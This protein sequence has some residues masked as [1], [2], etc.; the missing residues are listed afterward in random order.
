M[1]LKTYTEQLDNLPGLEIVG[2]PITDNHAAWLFTILVPDAQALRDY[3]FTKD[4]ESG[5]V[6]FRNDYYTIFGGRRNNLPNMDSVES[7]Y[8]VLPL[9]NHVTVED[10]KRIC[11]EVS[12][13]FSLE[14]NNAEV[15]AISNHPRL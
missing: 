9:H 12:T 14:K 4:I 1:L 13:F 8:L 5:Q 3:L 11:R 15:R 10:V 6:H 2:A 7:R